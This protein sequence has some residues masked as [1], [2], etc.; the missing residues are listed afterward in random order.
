MSDN[1][2]PEAQAT[3]LTARGTVALPEAFKDVR[4]K[5]GFDA[6]SGVTD[7]EGYA[8]FAIVSQFNRDGSSG[9]RAASCSSSSWGFG[10]NASGASRIR[11]T[12]WGR[13]R[14]ESPLHASVPY[15]FQIRAAL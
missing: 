1:R 3:M 4:Q 5:V 9:A 11:A 6:G 2:E 7:A 12:R 14:V 15:T 13:S 10:V 8:P